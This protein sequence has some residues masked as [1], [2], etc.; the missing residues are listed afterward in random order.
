M[1]VCHAE[2]QVGTCFQAVNSRIQLQILE[3]QYLPS[4]S[5]PLTLSKYVWCKV[6]CLKGV[7]DAKLFFFPAM[8]IKT[9]I[10]LFYLNSNFQILYHVSNLGHVHILISFLLVPTQL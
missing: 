3:A 2:L 9:L 6:K 5:T 8:E 10:L 1:Q 4:S 7:S